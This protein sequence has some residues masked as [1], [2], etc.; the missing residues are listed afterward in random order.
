MITTEMWLTPT[1]FTIVVRAPPPHLRSYP[2]SDMSSALSPTLQF[3]QVTRY[4]IIQYYFFFIF[5]PNSNK[6][7]EYCPMKGTPD[8]CVGE[9]NADLKR[10]FDMPDSPSW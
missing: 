9:N 6:G 3:N 4:A 8:L 2:S 7:T 1:L 10:R 5:K